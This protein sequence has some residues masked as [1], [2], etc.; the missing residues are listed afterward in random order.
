M[1]FTVPME[2]LSAAI[3]SK[4]KAA[5]SDELLRIGSLDAVRIHPSQGMEKGSGWDA[6]PAGA[7]VAAD[8]SLPGAERFRDLRVRIEG[9]FTLA[10]LP[11][12]RGDP[13]RFVG[14]AFPD[15]EALSRSVDSL[16]ESMQG[17]RERQKELQT[18]ILR[19]E[20]LGRQADFSAS[21][22]RKGAKGATQT[23]SSFLSLRFGTLPEGET[24]SVE[25][26]LASIAA[27][28]MPSG[29]ASDGRIPLAVLGLKGDEARIKAILASHGWE[30]IV[31]G[32]DS[33]FLGEQAKAEMEAKRR[34][35][36][37]DLAACSKEYTDLFEKRSGELSEAWARLKAAELSLRLRSVFA[38]TDSVAFLSGWIPAADR[39]RVE[40]V[41][42]KAADGRCYIEWLDVGAP[43][44]DGTEPPVAMEHRGFLAPFQ[45]LVTNF[46]V[47]G[48]GAVDPT[49]FVAAAYLSMFGLMFGDAGH[50]LVLVLAGFF[51]LLA[52][53]KKGKPEM[54]S[55]LI[56]YCG[57]AAIAAGLLFGSVFG[58]PL[59]P[60]LWF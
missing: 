48:Y 32:A 41:I 27:I 26:A 42:R 18:G 22:V 6:A 60:P 52:A 29:P 57:G 31:A 12:E 47:P 36:E 23:F 40:N 38:T 39:D 53:R 3:L 45:T 37:S 5:V 35:L 46:G 44:P 58:M 15:L 2:Y 54:L 50:G 1:M 8:D 59:L 30:D 4:D 56:I 55:K 17:I 43:A 10:G 51:L 21:R 28:V 49:P 20:E 9:L 11:L 16:V 25:A 34:R 13:A 33:P 7:G 14:Q 24:G 19:L